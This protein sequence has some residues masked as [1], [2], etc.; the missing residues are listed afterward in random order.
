MKACF[1]KTLDKYKRKALK[2]PYMLNHFLQNYIKSGKKR[3]TIYLS[4]ILYHLSFS[5]AYNTFVND[6]VIFFVYSNIN[7]FLCAKYASHFYFVVGGE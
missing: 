4:F 2:K 1:H 5:G 7:V 3:I 6:I